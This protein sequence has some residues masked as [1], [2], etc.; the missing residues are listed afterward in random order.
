MLKTSMAAIMV[1]IMLVTAFIVALAEALLIRT[2]ITKEW[3]NLGVNKALGFTSNQLITQVM[4]SNVPAITI[5][6]VL[7][8]ILVSLFGGK[9]M[10]LM[11][12]IFGFRKVAFSLS[13]VAYIG[14]IVVIFGV[15]MLVSWIN[16]KRI[17]KLE[18]VKMIT[19]E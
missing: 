12:T 3:R 17:K 4:L 19:E 18:P 14:V 15:A 6:I 9:V 7:G 8:L 1:I 10:L 2:R 5:G 16:G 11:F 13:P